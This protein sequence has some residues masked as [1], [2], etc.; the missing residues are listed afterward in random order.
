MNR[1][2]I[3][4][5]D[6]TKFLFLILFISNA[7][8]ANGQ[9]RLQ[10]DHITVENGM[11]SGSVLSIAQDGLGFLWVGTMDGLNRYDGN[12]IKTYKSLSM[13]NHL[14]ILQKTL[15]NITYYY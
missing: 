12:K 4:K 13:A 1:Y 5:K 6:P 9:K 2:N 3:I 11:S 10:F 7:W 15:V 14:P 8:I